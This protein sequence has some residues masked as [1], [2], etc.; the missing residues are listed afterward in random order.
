MNGRQHIGNYLF[1]RLAH[2]LGGKKMRVLYDVLYDYTMNC[3]IIL[4]IVRSVLYYVF[5]LAIL[6]II[7]VIIYLFYCLFNS[8]F[9]NGMQ[10]V[11]RAVTPSPA[12]EGFSRWVYSLCHCVVGSPFEYIPS[13]LVWLVRPLSIF[14]LPSRASSY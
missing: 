3:T 14:P 7:L 13:A 9:M 12:L 4:R 11:R 8:L 10:P 6:V 2:T 1:T 5:I